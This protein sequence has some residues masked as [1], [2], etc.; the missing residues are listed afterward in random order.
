MT[1][2]NASGINDGAAF[3]VLADA[4]TAKKAGHKPLA[5]SLTPLFCPNRQYRS[6]TLYRELKYVLVTMATPLLELLQRITSMLT[7]GPAS[8]DILVQA[9]IRGSLQLWGDGGPAS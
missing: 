1:A 6:D 8:V 9:R 7:A 4:E 5:R 2:G 3:F